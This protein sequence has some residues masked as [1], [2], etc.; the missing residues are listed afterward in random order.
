MLAS[1]NTLLVSHCISLFPQDSV[2]SIHNRWAASLL[3]YDSLTCHFWWQM[4]EVHYSAGHYFLSLYLYQQVSKTICFS[5]LTSAIPGIPGFQ[6]QIGVEDPH[7]IPPS[8]P[9]SLTVV[10]LL[11]CTFCHVADKR[12]HLD[13][14]TTQHRICL[15][16]WK[17]K[18]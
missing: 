9:P 5:T 15:Q 4:W 7:P 14:A 12:G 11:R 8:F 13:P 3:H 1:T 6:L 10:P 16:P 18:L 17:Q 2:S